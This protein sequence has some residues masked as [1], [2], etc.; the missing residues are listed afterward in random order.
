MTDVT[1]LAAL[2]TP[3]VFL[4][5]VNRD[6]T[7]TN[8]L[9]QSGILTPDPDLG[10]KLLSAGLTVQIPVLNDLT[11]D[12]QEWNDSTD[13]TTDSI[14]SDN[15]TEVK[16][17]DAKA[18]AFT[19]YSQQISGANVEQRIVSRFANYWNSVDEKR[20]LALVKTTFQND[21][22]KTAKAFNVGNEKTLAP[23]DFIGALARMGD[24]INNTLTKIAVNSS[25][26]AQMRR[27]NLIET[28]QGSVAGTTID[29]YNGMLI[30]LDD[31]IP[32]DDAGTTYALIYGN[33]AVKYSTATP[34]NGLATQRD[35]LKLGGSTSIIQKRLS[36]IHVVGTSLD[37]TQLT[38]GFAGFRTDLIN[39]TQALYKPSNDP[40]N[41]QIVMYGF[42]VDKDL[43]VPGIN[44]KK[45]RKT[46][47]AP[48]AGK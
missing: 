16:F 48:A 7:Q 9:I 3:Q 37:T 19:D 18:F 42:K 4:D 6:S 11:G 26:Y 25:A 44:T 33:G 38:N 17:S 22:I 32:V 8:R 40:R 46:P 28:I 23:G 10:N 47:A 21:D 43:V 5:W 30:V 34:A 35:E 14:D 12:P 24:V 27:L 2:Q 15:E 39:G 31:S 45:A 29:T 20:T 36:T 13:I 41:I 1:K